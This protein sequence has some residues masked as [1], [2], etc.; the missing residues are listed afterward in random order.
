MLKKKTVKKTCKSSVKR[1]KSGGWGI[2]TN[3]RKGKVKAV[4]YHLRQW[5][6]LPKEVKENFHN[7]KREYIA[8]LTKK[9]PS[10]KIK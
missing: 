2:D 10:L 6:Y 9:Y 5:E 4:K 8:W 7:N 1:K 3:K